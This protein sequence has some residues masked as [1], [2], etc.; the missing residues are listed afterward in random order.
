MKSS[1]SGPGLLTAKC[2]RP[3]PMH[4]ALQKSHT[5]GA[6]FNFGEESGFS[7][8]I[9]INLVGL[10]P[11]RRFSVLLLRRIATLHV[12]SD[13]ATAAQIALKLS[14]TRNQRQ[15]SISIYS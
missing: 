8:E 7:L 9:W 5:E 3:F 13:D 4:K 1:A 10:S 2:G 12:R 11:S 14:R 6:L 15:I